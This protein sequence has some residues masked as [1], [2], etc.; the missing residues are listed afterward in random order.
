MQTR[1]L[2]CP[3]CLGAHSALRF[4]RKSRP[5]FTCLACGARSF[6]PS[7]RDAIR[8]IALVQPLLVAQAEELEGDPDA[9]AR[10]AERERLVGDSLRERLRP[11]ERSTSKNES[12]STERANGTLR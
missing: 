5:Y 2:Q 12:E 8:S 11:V 4:D 7:L 6:L 3:F 1:D 10:A 9:R